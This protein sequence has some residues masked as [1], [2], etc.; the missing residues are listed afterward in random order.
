MAEHLYYYIK[1]Q[2][3]KGPYSLTKLR[4][5]GIKRDTLIWYEGLDNWTIAEN[6]EE[7]SSLFEHQPPRLP[8]SVDNTHNVAAAQSHT[9][10]SDKRRKMM[11]L[12]VVFFA[13]AIIGALL[14]IILL[15]N[16]EKYYPEMP[17]NKLE[18]D[19]LRSE[20]PLILAPNIKKPVV[21]LLSA[22]EVK[23][24][25]AT[26]AARIIQGTA[27][28]SSEKIEYGFPKSKKFWSQPVVREKDKAVAYLA[29]LKC[30][31]EYRYRIRVKYQSGTVLTDW[32][33]FTTLPKSVELT[34][35]RKPHQK[36]LFEWMKQCNITG[37]NRRLIEACDYDN[38]IVRNKAVSIAGSTPGTFNI[39]QVCDIYDYCRKNWKY[40]NDAKKK[41][42]VE[43]ASKTL[44]NGLNGDCDDFA[45]LVAS[46]IMAIG[47]EIRITYA[48]TEDSGHAFT[49]VNVGKSD[50][51]K[52]I[53]KYIMKR[54]PNGY[55][56][57]SYKRDADGNCWLNLDWW[58][59][60]PGGRYFEADRGIR[61]YLLEEYCDEF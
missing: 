29:N 61:F 60:Y 27:S 21:T 47:G 55:S 4:K 48:Y 18:S 52:D 31:T 39:G 49:E 16:R 58:D 14:C 19:S 6:L 41:S 25:S 46:M 40:V 17:E 23:S 1:N 56:S 37:K 43:Y 45:V 57:T 26:V 50:L 13:V 9:H 51:I 32:M 12:A 30:E 2:K 11:S 36:S 10:T 44:K 8:K 20:S 3:Q 15:L 24:T 54:Y 38:D 22:S 5:Q 53:E 33:T 7:L 59:Y 35:K 28:I 42:T 34:S